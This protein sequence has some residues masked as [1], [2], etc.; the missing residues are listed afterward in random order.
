MRFWLRRRSKPS[1]KLDEGGLRIVRG[2]RAEGFA[3]NEVVRIDA[4]K[5]D[6]Y[7]VDCICLLF[8][9]RDGS[10]YEVQED[11]DGFEALENEVHVQFEHIPNDWWSQVAFPAFAENRTLL[12]SFQQ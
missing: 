11:M 5:L 1:I 9:L 10:H 12:W 4:Y 2:A 3:W 7:T 6:C 8:A